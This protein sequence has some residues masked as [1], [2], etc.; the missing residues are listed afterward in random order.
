MLWQ[1]LIMD[2]LTVSMEE[3]IVDYALCIQTLVTMGLALESVPGIASLVLIVSRRIPSLGLTFAMLLG[4]DPFPGS[5]CYP[6][7]RRSI[8]PW[9]VLM[10]FMRLDVTQVGTD[11]VPTRRITACLPRS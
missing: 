9:L 2:G 7:R 8:P 3:G 4:K 11:H 5:C 1:I 6:P 10:L